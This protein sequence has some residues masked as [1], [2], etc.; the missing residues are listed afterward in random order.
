MQEIHSYSKTNIDRIRDTQLPSTHG[1]SNDL[2]S[3]L[4]EIYKDDVM[5]PKASAL[6]R[7]QDFTIKTWFSSSKLNIMRDSQGQNQILDLML[8]TNEKQLLEYQRR[9]ESI[10]TKK[11][12]IIEDILRYQQSIETYDRWLKGR[13]A[14]NSSD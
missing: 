5:Q 12:L 2:S 6:L 9:L 1:L 11:Q 8:L 14:I 13:R 3:V 7:L 10:F 4:T